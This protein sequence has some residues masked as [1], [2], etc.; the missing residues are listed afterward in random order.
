MQPVS[1]VDVL[2]CISTHKFS[3]PPGVNVIF[4]ATGSGD[5]PRVITIIE[6]LERADLVLETKDK[7]HSQRKIISLTDLGKETITVILLLKMLEHRYN[8]L[9][10]VIKQKF[11]ISED[12]SIQNNAKLITNG[13]K[14]E[15]RKV[16]EEYKWEISHI[17][18][19]LFSHIVAIPLEKYIYLNHEYHPNKIASMFLEEQILESMTRFLSC[20][21]GD[22][23]LLRRY[24][25]IWPMRV[26]IGTILI[27]SEDV[28][29]YLK[30]T[31]RFI[32]EE[33]TELLAILLLL[34][35]ENLEEMLENTNKKS[36]NME[37]YK[38]IENNRLFY[39][40][41]KYTKSLGIRSPKSLI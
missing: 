6:K 24:H 8:N 21:L 41:L 40:A 31:S 1:E 34:T 20:L 28:M 5:K 29:K 7:R 18:S 35:G 22:D 32:Y 12:S 16:Y 11:C 3:R 39:D 38:L 17:E 2:E 4:R 26:D 10:R 15:E 19:T 36:E 9:R 33:L 27:F 25:G 14:P 37:I 23:A 30:G 13:W